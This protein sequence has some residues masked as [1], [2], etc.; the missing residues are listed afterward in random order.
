MSGGGEIRE[1][2]TTEGSVHREAAP[3]DAVF[4]IGYVAV[5]RIHLFGLEMAFDSR[6][7]RI[8]TG[9]ERRASAEVVQGEEHDPLAI[10]LRN[11]QILHFL[12][13]LREG[14]FVLSTLFISPKKKNMILVMLEPVLFTFA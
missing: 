5:L 6:V 2:G 11:R 7:R 12:Q 3:D 14:N 8:A 9:K 1:E 10:A 13:L 4:Q